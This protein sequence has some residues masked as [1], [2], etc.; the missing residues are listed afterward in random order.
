M[1]ANG[2]PMD[3]QAAVVYNGTL[4]SQVSLSGTITELLQRVKEH[5][6]RE[7]A[8]L[9]VGRVAGLREHLR[10]YDSKPLFGTCVLVTRPREQAAEL[11][12]RL[13]ALGA[14]SV[15][16]PMIRIDP[17]EDPEP[18]R[19]AAAEASTFDWIV[20]TSAN[21]V[22]ALMGA[23]FEVGLDVRALAGPQLCAVG[24]ATADAM[25]RYGIQVDLVPAEF[26]A[27]GLVAAIL[28]RGPLAGARVL[29]PRADIGR[30]VI[31]ERLRQAGAQVTEAVAYRTVLEDPLR[32]GAPDVY[33]ML[34]DGR[35]DVVTFTS[36]SA[37]RNF[38]QVYG[39]DQAADLLRRTMVAAI[40]PVTAEAAAQLGIPITIQ[41]TT[42]TIAALVDAILAHVGGAGLAKA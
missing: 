29:L 9:V 23:I 21:A 22:D 40:G 15:E 10:W 26:R 25:A 32:E 1:R 20:L 18:L 7:P 41:P 30:E 13:A 4:P 19:R 38:A 12:D 33:R 34:L 31:A 2:W 8:I 14:D 42:Y 6:R 11:V 35:I 3:G 17:P 27:E 37:V 5:P 28:A 39:A 24:S 16:A 36:A